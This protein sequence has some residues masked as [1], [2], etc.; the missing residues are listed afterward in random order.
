M[1]TGSPFRGQGVAGGSG[2]LS[3]SKCKKSVQISLICGQ[4]RSAYRSEKMKMNLTGLNLE[5]VTEPVEVLV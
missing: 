5:Q 3:L 2:A 1:C 4:K